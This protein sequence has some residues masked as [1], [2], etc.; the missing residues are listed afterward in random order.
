MPTVKF[1]TLDEAN[2]VMEQLPPEARDPISGFAARELAD[3]KYE[4]TVP[5][6]WAGA[7]KSAD[8][9]RK[10]PE[11]VRTVP[12]SL[13][14]DRLTAAGKIHDAFTALIAEPALFARWFAPDRQVVNSNDQDTIA[15]IEAL[16]EDPD[17]ILARENV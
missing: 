8:P 12:K 13:V 4:L 2:N 6:H 14:M 3:G 1:D 9:D 15:F 7:V 16:G 5:N 17:A 10:P 11:P